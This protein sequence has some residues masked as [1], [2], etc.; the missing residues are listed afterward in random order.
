MNVVGELKCASAP[1]ESVALDLFR[2]GVF[3]VEMLF[4]YNLKSS[5]VFQAVGK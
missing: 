1:K 4:E 5:I 3:G 2:L